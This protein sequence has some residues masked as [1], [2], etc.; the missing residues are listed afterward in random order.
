MEL[1]VTRHVAFCINV[2]GHRLWI[3]HQSLI[4]TLKT[5]DQGFGVRSQIKRVHVSLKKE[6]DSG[7]CKIRTLAK[8]AIDLVYDSLPGRV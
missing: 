7:G 5:R 2:V 3:R 1:A 8:C 4:A 6:G